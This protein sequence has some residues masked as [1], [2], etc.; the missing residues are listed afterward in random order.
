LLTQ[1]IA[2]LIM[3]SIN[4]AF[5]G[6]RGGKILISARLDGRQVLLDVADDGVGASAAV[7]ARMFEPF[8]TTKRGQGGSGL[9][10]YIVQTIVQRL[11]GSIELPEL[12][13]GLC[14]RLRLPIVP[15]EA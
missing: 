10:L 8:F 13:Q 12:E 3:N 11:G 15:T 7:R 2:N 1:V 6:R 4:H 5:S 14:V 9:G